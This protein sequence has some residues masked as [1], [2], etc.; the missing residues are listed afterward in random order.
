MRE[1]LLLCIALYEMA[2]TK[3]KGFLKNE[4]LP[5]VFS[6]PF[7]FNASKLSLGINNYELLFCYTQKQS[8]AG[9]LR[10]KF[11]KKFRKIHRTKYVP[12]FKKRL[13]QR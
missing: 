10:N 8:F 12:F 5:Q 9:V 6:S 7:S 11:S 3:R 1:N 4:C 13:R 2:F